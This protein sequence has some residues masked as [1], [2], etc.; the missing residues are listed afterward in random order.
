MTSPFTPNR[1]DAIR[2]GL[3]A[4]VASTRPRRRMAWAAA[5]LVAIGAIAG[6]G[7]SAGAF[8]ATD[9]WS[10]NAREAFEPGD[11]IVIE[12]PRGGPTPALTDPVV[13]PAGVIP[14]LPVITV[15]GDPIS[16]SVMSPLEVPL[17]ERP[18]GTTHVRVTVT[19]LTPGTISWGTDPDG[20]NPSSSCTSSDAGSFTGTAW[21]DLPLDATT[22]TLFIT[23]EGAATAGVTMQY[24]NYVP[25]MFGVNENGETYGAGM[26]D[27][28]QPDLILVEATGSDGNPI[29]G[30]VRTV[31][32]N[33]SI[34]GP[35]HTDDPATP[36]E[37]VQ[38]AA[39]LEDKYPN[40]WDIP[41]YESDGTTQI[42]T[43]HLGR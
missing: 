39:E 3:I 15:V 27:Q 28:G 24:V 16:F 42:G 31:D 5:G 20:N 19:C 9:N 14:G 11:G 41:V 2:A 34:W 7:V 22:T 37:A 35:D 26:S 8:A 4:N 29:Q 23:P 21:L 17:T 18:E 12:Q 36:E 43:F 10:S 6:A 33:P 40:G 25:T 32:M 1:S 30:Y 13:A 38:W